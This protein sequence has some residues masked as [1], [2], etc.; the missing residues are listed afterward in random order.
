MS[1]LDHFDP[2]GGPGV[3]VTGDRK[4]GEAFRGHF[5]LV[6]VMPLGDL[7]HGARGLAGGENNEAA[8][9]GRRRQVPRQAV[10][11]VRGLDRAA[12]QAVQQASG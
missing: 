8:F 4:P 9:G 5:H 12:E 1:S 6:E 11:R 3:A 2:A 10:D 7:G